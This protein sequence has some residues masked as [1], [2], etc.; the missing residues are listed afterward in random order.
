M[1]DRNFSALRER[2]DIHYRLLDQVRE[3]MDGYEV[4]SYCVGANL[5]EILR[6][7]LSEAM[8]IDVKLFAEIE[9]AKLRAWGL[10]RA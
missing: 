9:D 4:G 10:R 7:W 1:R 6:T 8:E 5:P 3:I 2:R